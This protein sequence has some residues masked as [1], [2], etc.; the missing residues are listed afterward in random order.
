MVLSVL[1]SIFL[2]GVDV[3]GALCSCQET[4]SFT[5]KIM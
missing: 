1:R 2:E 3:E 5:L 4:S